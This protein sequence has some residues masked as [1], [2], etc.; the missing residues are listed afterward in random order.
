VTEKKSESSDPST[1][2]DPASLL[3]EEG[4]SSSPGSS[5]DH[6][7][8]GES[9][10]L[11]F[12]GHHPTLTLQAGE[13]PPNTSG[14]RSASPQIVA[15]PLVASQGQSVEP[16]TAKVEEQVRPS[17]QRASLALP[18]VSVKSR[19]AAF[20][21]KSP[22]ASTFGPSPP[23]P[24]NVDPVSRNFPVS[25]KKQEETR[26]LADTTRDL[27]V[28]RIDLS[29]TNFPSLPP[30]VHA[31]AVTRAEAVRKAEAAR[32][33]EAARRA[34]E[35]RRAPQG[36]FGFPSSVA[37]DSATRSTPKSEAAETVSAPPTASPKEC[38]PLRAPPKPRLRSTAQS[39]QA[40]SP[41]PETEPPLVTT[42]ALASSELPEQPRTPRLGN[43]SLALPIRSKGVGGERSFPEIS[44]PQT[45]LQIPSFGWRLPSGSPLE[46]V[47]H[48]EAPG[49]RPRPEDALAR[50]NR[51]KPQSRLSQVIR[52]ESPEKESPALAQ[53]EPS[54]FDDNDSDRLFLV[55]EGYFDIER[56]SSTHRNRAATLRSLEGLE[57]VEEQSPLSK[58]SK[59]S[60][61]E[62]F[63]RSTERF[64]QTALIPRPLKSSRTA[65]AGPEAKDLAHRQS[66]S[67][68]ADTYHSNVSN[69]RFPFDTA[70]EKGPDTVEEVQ[71]KRKP[72]LLPSVIPRLGYSSP[73]STPRLP[74]AEAQTYKF[75]IPPLEGASVSDF[76]KPSRRQA[77]IP[78]SPIRYPRYPLSSGPYTEPPFLGH[79]HQLHPL[80]PTRTWWPSVTGEQP[81]SLAAPDEHNVLPLESEVKLLQFQHQQQAKESGS[82][83]YGF[84]PLHNPCRS[85]ESSPK[86]S[87]ES[88]ETP[89]P[90][91]T[92]ARVQYLEV[93]VPEDP[94][95]IIPRITRTLIQHHLR[96]SDSESESGSD[97]MDHLRPE[98][99]LAVSHHR[100]EAMRL[101]KAQETSVIEKCRRSG[102]SVPEYAFD[103]LIGKGSFGRVY[104]W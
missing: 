96:P 85:T 44:R 71:R 20:E 64:S 62:D 35:E 50:Q 15:A 104:K 41:S 63:G 21:N 31:E 26:A 102:A 103:E 80:G 61:G 99:A 52:A 65:A 40:P 81:A 38:T 54:P 66:I 100:R 92:E 4:D 87:P 8:E 49:P 6:P 91:Q 19:I 77:V 90:R 27:D 28:T 74:E 25:P 22:T 1:Q 39:L 101:A 67:T 84:D 16:E 98:S 86:S 13:L 93:P 76:D 29:E 23:R 7:V 2:T 36:G 47:K 73:P 69:F 89:T 59:S 43:A 53:T 3:D 42:S 68:G 78:T 18:R 12:V 51:F 82:G 32:R 45:R 14:P 9:A 94:E 17:A 48:N 56:S 60:L 30:S 24:G 83:R 55:P 88:S 57:T 34:A 37:R 5:P 33:L 72:T 11:A 10:Y 97:I 58:T 70:Q 79:P 46:R 95:E 75:C